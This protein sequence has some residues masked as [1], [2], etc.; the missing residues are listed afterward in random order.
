MATKF[1]KA[2]MAIGKPIKKGFES[3]LDFVKF[4]GDLSFNDPKA[5]VEFA[6]ENV[7]DAITDVYNGNNYTESEDET[8]A[9]EEVLT[10]LIN[11]KDIQA[12]Q[13]IGVLDAYLT[14]ESN[15]VLTKVTEGYYTNG[16]DTYSRKDGCKIRLFNDAT[17]ATIELADVTVFAQTAIRQFPNNILNDGYVNKEDSALNGLELLDIG[18]EFIQW[19]DHVND[20][21]NFL[22]NWHAILPSSQKKHYYIVVE[23]GEW[24]HLFPGDWHTFQIGDLTDT[25]YSDTT[26]EILKTVCA[27]DA[28][29][30]VF[31]GTVIS[32]IEVEENWD[33]DGSATAR[34][35]TSGLYNALSIRKNNISVAASGVTGEWDLYCDG[36]NDEEQIQVAIDTLHGNGS[37]GDVLLSSG[38]F[39]V[40]TTAIAYKSGIR[41]IGEGQG[42]TFI[43]KNLND[44]AIEADGG[45]GTEI[46]NITLMNLTVT[47]NASDTNSKSLIFLDYTD[48]FLI[49]NVT[50]DDSYNYGI[51]PTN[52]DGGIILNC[53]FTDFLISAISGSACT[54]IKIDKNTVT[55]NGTS[56]YRGVYF[57]GSSKINVTDNTITG[58]HDTAAQSCY[59]IIFGGVYTEITIIGNMLNAFTGSNSAKGIICIYASG[60]K[61]NISSN[62]IT[63]MTTT[64]CGCYGIFSAG[65]YASI[66]GNTI[67]ALANSGG[68]AG[69]VRGIEMQ[70]DYSICNNNIIKNLSTATTSNGG[71]I[72][73]SAFYSDYTTVTGNIIQG[74]QTNHATNA[75]PCIGIYCG[76]TYITVTG[77]SIKGI[78]IKLGTNNAYGIFILQDSCTVSSNTIQTV[79]DFGIWIDGTSDDSAVSANIIEGCATGI[80][81]DTGANNT[82]VTGNRATGNATDNF[83]D[84]GTATTDSGNDWT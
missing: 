13:V 29:G 70:G 64:G 23:E 72:G 17:G 81:V 15:G 3:T 77:N 55:G 60:G 68:A 74:L 30:N 18:N 22:G 48:N 75:Q 27:R 78:T 10:K 42:A 7:V 71:I 65:T 31:G 54:N 40:E 11:S 34:F 51:E 26:F 1:Q 66:N 38:T 50:I 44:Y 4:L 69:E 25:I 59:G 49:E 5:F 62:T 61:C 39:Y 6:V 41:I 53:V 67:D 76:V 57:T 37:Y 35:L 24:L 63:S 80:E 46:T 83:D 47:R 73:I 58:L 79:T 28:N 82:V 20:L 33:S 12:P 45:S 14:E 19:T 9:T 36:V 16:L 8:S 56:S 84:N 43:E 2:M 32:A 52:C 21:A